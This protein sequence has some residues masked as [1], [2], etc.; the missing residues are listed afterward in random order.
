MFGAYSEG[1]VNSLSNMGKGTVKFVTDPL[2]TAS[3]TVNYF[4][5]D[6]LRNNPVSAILKTQYDIEMAIIHHDYETAAYKLGG[7]TSEVAVAGITGGVTKGIAGKI[8]GKLMP[9]GIHINK[10]LEFKNPFSP[11]YAVA[12]GLEVCA[13]TVSIPISIKISAEAAAKMAGGVVTAAATQNIVYSKTLAGQSG[14]GEHSN[15]NDSVE[16]TLK[17]KDGMPARQFER[18]ANALKDLGIKVC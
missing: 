3:E 4:L 16:I 13:G 8:T 5:E 14:G 18:K 1:V 15:I 11:R 10:T 6:P 2:G 7:L 12:G 17:Y 9:E